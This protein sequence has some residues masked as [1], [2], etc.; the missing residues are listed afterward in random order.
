[1]SK[2][3]LASNL[4]A[5]GLS[6]VGIVGNSPV[7]RADELFITCPSGRSGVATTV[8]SCE[9]ADNVRMNFFRQGGPLVTTYSPVT[10]QYYTM[11]CSGGF[12]AHLNNGAYVSS[13]RCVGGNNAVVIVW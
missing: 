8:T 7:A 5:M 2:K 6:V 12:T 4:I 1:V 3:L 9:F 10:G 11:Q 13:A